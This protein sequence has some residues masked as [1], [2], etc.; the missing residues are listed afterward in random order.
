M[1][2]IYRS[3]LSEKLPWY[4]HVHGLPIFVDFIV[5]SNHEIKFPMKYIVCTVYVLWEIS[6]HKLKNTQFND[7]SADQEN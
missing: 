2:K 6:N 1:L 5:N 4:D 7:L 3:Q